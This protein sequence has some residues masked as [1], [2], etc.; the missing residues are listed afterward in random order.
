MK[1][2]NFILESRMEEQKTEILQFTKD[3]ISLRGRLDAL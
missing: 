3:N 1:S 2:R